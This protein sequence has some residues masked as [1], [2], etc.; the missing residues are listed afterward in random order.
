M[1]FSNLS[2][3]Q[4]VLLEPIQKLNKG[5]VEECAV[6]DPFILFVYLAG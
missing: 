5:L 3:A 2:D 4:N 1:C 6:Y